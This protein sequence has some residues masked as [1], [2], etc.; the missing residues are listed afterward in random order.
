MCLREAMT[1]L[2]KPWSGLS[3]MLNAIHPQGYLWRQS[4]FGI[5][6]SWMHASSQQNGK[7]EGDSWNEWNCFLC[8]NTAWWLYGVHHRC[9]RNE[10]LQFGGS[11]QT[12][13]L[14]LCSVWFCLWGG[15]R[16]PRYSKPGANTEHLNVKSVISIP[17]SLN[18][19]IRSSVQQRPIFTLIY[20]DCPCTQGLIT[21]YMVNKLLTCS[22]Q[23]V[24]F[25]Q[26]QCVS[27]TVTGVSQCLGHTITQ[28]GNVHFK[29]SNGLHL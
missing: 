16:R 26:R 28:G 18:I 4:P 15:N 12:R 24:M 25:T 11:T 5:C 13:T 10:W 17:K 27:C 29:R 8:V 3:G 20:H 1:A 23:C 9:V 19:E 7:D 2:R 21:P 22:R 6:L 14:S